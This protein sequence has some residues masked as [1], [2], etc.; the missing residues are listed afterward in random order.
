M[1]SAATTIPIPKLLE[2]YAA[3]LTTAIS[4]RAIMD[5]RKGSSRTAQ[6]DKWKVG[7]AVRTRLND[8]S[9]LPGISSAG[10]ARAKTNTG[11]VS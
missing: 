11:C 8:N 2:K 6:F 1:S 5:V 4:T 3:A 7:G 9:E 10:L